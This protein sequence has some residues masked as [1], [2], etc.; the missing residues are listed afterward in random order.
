MSNPKPTKKKKMTLITKILIGLLAFMGVLI[1]F[2][3]ISVSNIISN[4][5]KKDM[6]I[7][8]AER[9]KVIDDY[10]GWL[11][12]TIDFFAYGS[13][14]TDILM[15]PTDSALQKSVQQSTVDYA[16]D[17]GVLEGL[18]IAS[19]DGITLCHS[20]PETVGTYVRQGDRLKE[21]QEILI[22]NGDQV[23]TAGMLVSPSSGQQV[24]AAYKAIYDGNKPIGFV[25]V[26]VPTTEVLADLSKD[27]ISG[28]EN[29]EYILLDTAA[30]TYLYSEDKSLIGKKTDAADLLNIDDMLRKGQA[31][32]SG[33]GIY[34]IPGSVKM[35]ST[36][37]YIDEYKW[38]LF[39]N[40]PHRE[41]LKMAY[42]I[43]Y[44]V[45]FMGVLIMLLV[46][47]FGIINAHQE[48]I[49]R[50]LGS[51]L[52]K[53]EATQESLETAM[54]KDILTEASNRISL[55]M[56]LDKV[57]PDADHPCYFGMFDI[58]EL[59]T[60]NAQ[61]GNDVGDTVLVNTAQILNKMFPDGT[62]YRTGDD[63]FV[64]AVQK[65][66]NSTASYN[67]VYRQINDAHGELLKPQ[68]T[69]DGTINVFYKV[70]LVRTTTELST[71]V[72][73]ILKDMTNRGGRSN[74]GQLNFVDMD[75]M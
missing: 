46:G 45:L 44:F 73:S 63:E 52:L 7:V 68:E 61:F 67:Q 15:H 66:D 20:N 65:N 74:P 28:L 2:V 59:S 41:V 33:I 34:K 47:I 10:V 24:I 5:K 35:I 1:L 12:D 51:Q 25:G 16:E 56:D 75:T 17:I 70:A 55:S 36:Y 53:N 9:A 27:Q 54:F 29:C 22:A 21:L 57:Q 8:A 31:E 40:A 50:K 43:Q 42:Q 71:D 64:I 14:V 23:Y 37:Q 6:Q 48:S 18:Y 39:L 13:Q 4:N 19:W 72:I 49:N 38:T 30:D 60:I 62:V 3:A 69:P 58:C 26:A 11:E 32:S